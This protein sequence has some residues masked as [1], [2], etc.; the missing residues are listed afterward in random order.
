MTLSDEVYKL[1][2]TRHS[3]RK[4]QDKEVLHDDIIK[5]INCGLSAPSAMN[6]QPWF[7]VVVKDRKIISKLNSLAKKSFKCS[8]EQWRIKWA[9][10]PDFSPFYNPNALILVCN[11]KD[12]QYSKNDCCF[13]VQNMSIMAESLGL[14]TCIIQDICWAIDENNKSGF[15]IPNDY[16]IYLALSIGYPYIIN[17]NKKII[18]ATKYTIIGE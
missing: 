1:I 11:K 10:Q 16:E 7:F 3:C 13:A 2:T 15:Q 9:K 4:F 6:R 8:G 12:I 18:D 17:N 5:I 14:G